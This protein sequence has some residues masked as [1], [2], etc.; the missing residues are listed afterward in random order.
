[1][2][3]RRAV[4]TGIGPITC[5]GT[6]RENFWNGLRAEKSG[7]RTIASFDTSPFNAH[8]AGEILD[9]VPEEHYPPHRLKRLDRYAQF[10]VASA[11]MALDDARLPYSRETPQ[12]RV[13][14]SFGTALGGIS[15]AEQDHARF[16]KKGT[17][18]V[19]P[20]LA[21]QVFGGSGHSNI[22]IEFGLRGVGTTNSNSCASGTVSIGEALRYIRDDMADVIVA[23]AAEAP[24]SPLTFGAFAIIKSMSQWAGDPA[25]ACRP[26]DLKRDGFVMGE[27][28][29]S[30]IIEELEHAQRRGAH[31]YAEVLGYSLNNDAFHMTSP[32]PTAESTIRAMRESLADAGVRPDQIDYINA[33]AS[34]T[35]LNDS[36][37]TM[38]IKQ[39]F[40]SRAN[41]IPVSGTKAF[42]AHA[43]GATG[44]MEG[45]ICA[46]ALD[47]NWIPP[48]L[49]RTNPDPACDLDVVPDHGRE[50]KLNYVMSNSFG[51][52]GINA[53]VIFGR[54]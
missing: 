54:L 49:N 50:A 41:Q 28:G 44:A 12:H 42:T 33:H 38:A 2:S 11:K 6:G 37:E 45:A 9:W 40:G 25:L 18:G 8:C 20:T 3:K 27:G 21:V 5:I 1:M 4:I 47:R 32:L 22:A 19:N 23:G 7:I 39:V 13:G 46:L 24:L 52:G 30:V 35:P 48:T 16:L 15:N 51:F 53:C 36:S 43:L 17:R 10:A 26:F 29:A 31:I 34:S 14:V